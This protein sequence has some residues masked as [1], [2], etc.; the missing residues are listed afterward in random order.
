MAA[1]ATRV[2]V[3][4]AEGTSPLLGMI[5]VMPEAMPAP[6]GKILKRKLAVEPGG[7]P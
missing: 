3:P 4:P 7:V 2:E 6:L 1:A 5:E